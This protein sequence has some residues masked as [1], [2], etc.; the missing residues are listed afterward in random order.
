MNIRR[1]IL[2]LLYI[3]AC[4]LVAQAYVQHINL[5]DG[6]PSRQVYE[7]EQ[8]KDGFIWVFTNSGL[9][10]YDGNSFKHYMLEGGEESNDHIL[11]ATTMSI[12]P[13]EAVWVVL[14]SGLIYRYD[15]NRDRFEREFTFADK[16]VLLY[17]FTFSPDGAL[18]V[19]SNNGLFLCER[20][21]EPRKVALDGVFTTAVTGDGAGAW[22]AGTSDGVYHV[23]PAAD[24]WHAEFV[25]GTENLYVR[26]IKVVAGRLFVGSFSKGITIIDLATG[27][28]VRPSFEIPP[29]PV[30][31]MTRLGTEDLLI[32]VDG[33]GVYHMNARTGRLIRH[34]HDGESG[35]EAL[36]GNTISD[37]LVDSDMGLWIA[38]SHSGINYV[39]PYSHAVGTIRSVRGNK[40]SLV[41][42]Y[43]NVVFE[44]ADGDLWFGTDKGLSCNNPS[45]G[46]WSR[47]LQSSGYVAGVYLAVGQAPDGRIWAGSYG[48]GVSIIDKRTGAVERIPTRMAGAH[49]GM[50][51]DYIFAVYGDSRGNMWAGGINGSLTRYDTR[52]GSWHYYDEDCIADIT[53]DKSAR[54]LF[55]GN[56]GVG[57]YDHVAD[58]FAWQT[59]FDTV[60]IRYP[61]RAVL[62]DTVADVLWVGTTG[63][64]LIRY[65][66]R[67]GK[68][69]R[70]TTADG[71]SSNT[72]Y[73][74]ERDHAGFIWVCTES[75]LYR[76]D[77]AHGKV[78]RL[79]YY[80]GSSSCAF[81]PGGTLLTRDG[82]VM[83]GT[84][85]GCIHF[86]PEDDFGEAPHNVI[87]LTDFKVHDR[88]VLPG[89]DGSPLAL[90]INLTDRVELLST[91][92]TIE[93]DFAV[94]N[95]AAPQRVGFEY[96]LENHDRGFSAATPGHSAKYTELAPGD[97]LFRLRAVDLY[98]DKVL[99]E[100]TLRIT[101]LP[102]VWLT[103]WARLIYALLAAGVVVLVAGTLR[104]RSR[105]K[106]IEA[107][108]RSF[109]SLAHDI[110]TP[111][112]LIK[113]PLLSVENDENLSEAARENLM[114]ARAG[115]DKTMQM[116]SEMLE[117]P[118]SSGRPRSLQ[119][120]LRD[121]RE[122]LE[123]KVADFAPLARFK[124]LEI[125][126]D[127][128]DDMPL[129]MIDCDTFDHIVDNLISNAIKYTEKGGVRV[130]AA[131][132][133]FNR[134]R[135]SVSD[136]GIGISR[137][138]ARH[139]FRHRH[140]S[141]GA[142]ASDAPGV[143]IGLL[144]TRRLVAMHKGAIDFEST[145]GQGTTFN[146]T[147]PRTYWRRYQAKVATEA[148]PAGA[149]EE[150]EAS[151]ASN[152]SR[153]FVIEDDPDML[154]FLKD[155]LSME[156]DVTASADGMQMLE[157]IREENPDLIVSD[158]MMPR[159]RGDELCRLVKTDMATS[160][161]P[162]ILLTGLGTRDDIV[163]GLDARADDY[164]VKPFD[165][166]VL[167]ARIRN[168]IK[169]RR[170]LSKRVIAE[171]C[172][173]AEEDFSNELDREFMTKVMAS[174]DAHLS[175]SEFSVG[176]LCADLGMS[177]TSVYNKIK[178]ISG[179]SLN[180]FIRIVRL[181]RS[182]ELLST[183]RYNISEVAYM[184]G[185]SDPKYF[186]TCFKKQFGVSPSKM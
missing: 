97:Y 89:H 45:T 96:M 24:G 127:V 14:K 178:A 184:V 107:Q 39:P 48:D 20:G 155:S 171:D 6:L 94:I 4:A 141:A 70:F 44:D 145:P 58:R 76:I 82:T 22:Y 144:I 41:S 56:K 166:V 71:L 30:N 183:R 174:V 40:A 99:G 117:L 66:R 27:R 12:A 50:G 112:S 138:D 63:D 100:R 169:S 33:A 17:N 119:V 137:A 15:R 159:L 37:V 8:D 136:T 35:D 75:D 13:D 11:S 156:Y 55:G 122:Y 182:K 38:T 175:D 173:P 29:I 152:R 80:L 108:I 23:K 90:N 72:I 180:E 59:E 146:V 134:W 120:E 64:G 124:G 47:H 163:A 114:Q 153:I 116:L 150:P 3:M 87:Q 165:I 26:S 85:E 105:E 25:P 84:A 69:K 121:I 78:S 151:A 179:Q 93:I 32:G 129:V 111:V 34:Y 81:N 79:T 128:P 125:T 2:P 95:Y 61:V 126:L 49:E 164:I 130:S 135:L 118:R 19:C 73:G 68:A 133:R 102:P 162:V 53:P 77:P 109:S 52:D 181:N 10:R 142:V 62:A 110:R 160:H 158:I 140:R 167:R 51:S 36:S 98:S 54:L 148:R 185:F 170:A 132:L 67:T 168:I 31:D 92:N 1:A 18:I 88:T 113:A 154:R 7:L 106:R 177:R 28:P 65:D 5:R 60:A 172:R 176:D 161:I 139:I 147:L 131:L 157:K 186:S 43:V 149:E 57:A 74:V 103:W 83:L 21:E 123:L 91:Q 115:I 143:G 9:D 46:A 104:H 16:S 42:D 101:V 86:N